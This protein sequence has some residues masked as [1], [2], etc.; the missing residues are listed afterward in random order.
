MHFNVSCFQNIN[1][2]F[3]C[4]LWMQIGKDSTYLTKFNFIFVGT[5]LATMFVGVITPTW[6][7]W[8]KEE[9]GKSFN[10]EL[11]FQFLRLY[12]TPRKNLFKKER[13]GASKHWVLTKLTLMPIRK[14]LGFFHHHQLRLLVQFDDHLTYYCCAQVA[15]EIIY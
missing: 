2:D 4:F 11:I 9:R 14:N 1:M 6:W 5:T 12:V 15:N 8:L 7:V 13:L 3:F 10:I